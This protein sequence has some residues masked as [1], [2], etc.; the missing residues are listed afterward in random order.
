MK[1]DDEM[2]EYVGGILANDAPPSGL[3]QAETDVMS[4]L[5]SAMT[6]FAALP[7]Q[8]PDELREFVSAIHRLQDLMAARVVQRYFPYYWHGAEAE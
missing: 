3:T 4:A 2:I 5:N 8:H 6:G 7:R 1:D